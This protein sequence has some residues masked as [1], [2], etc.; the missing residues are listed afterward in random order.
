MTGSRHRKGLIV[1]AA[2]AAALA[3]AVA[4]APGMG[5][6]Q[7]RIEPAAALPG[8]FAPAVAPAPASEL[9]GGGTRVFDD[10]VYVALYGHPGAAA[11]GVLGEQGRAATIARAKR[12]AAKYEGHTA[13]TVVPALEV[14]AT[15]ATKGA[16]ADGDYSSETS[17]AALR[18]LVDAA[19]A[20]G[21]YVV[22]DLQPGRS[23]FLS[24]AKRYRD[25][26]ELPH[27]GLAL[28]PE[29]RLKPGQRHLRQIGSVSAAEINDV[30]DW[31]AG[32]TREA[33]SPQKMLLLHQ[34]RPSM[35]RKRSTLD[36][37]RPEIAAVVQ[38][39]GL[40]SQGAKRGTWA[41]IRRNAPEGLRFGW[42]NFIDED[43]PMLSPR[44]TMRVRPQPVWVSYQ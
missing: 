36:L 6:G 33:R 25:L 29:W 10:K 31:L 40:G 8:R 24:Q 22:L 13:R 30:I 27:V 37:S 16:G 21:V 32:V 2:S 11:L 3:S 20:A 15:I 35:I 7:A 23:T 1:A 19:G 34:F 26:L 14:I 41:A 5:L 4:A 44:A 9:P 42:K 17:V 28:D 12:T 43:R 39:D 38:M 18:P